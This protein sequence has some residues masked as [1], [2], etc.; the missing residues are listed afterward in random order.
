M[1]GARSLAS[2]ERVGRWLGIGL[3]GLVNT[4]NP[5]LVVLGGVIGRVHPFVAEVVERELDR[6]ALAAPRALVRVV[7]GALGSDAPLIGAAELAFDP[8][9]SDPVIVAGPREVVLQL[10]SA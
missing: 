9:L 1:A 5:G 8:V 2:V 10:A 4:F 7:P 3:A 6:R